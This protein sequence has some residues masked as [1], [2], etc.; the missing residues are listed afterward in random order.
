MSKYLD[1][2]DIRFILKEYPDQIPDKLI[3]DFLYKLH[4]YI[5]INEPLS[6]TGIR[7][8]V[9]KRSIDFHSRRTIQRFIDRIPEN[10]ARRCNWDVDPIEYTEDGEKNYVGKIEGRLEFMIKTKAKGLRTIFVWDFENEHE[11]YHHH[12]DTNNMPK[13]QREVLKEVFV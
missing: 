8:R 10:C 1:M 5:D 9:W 6:K 7:R 11:L 13:L 4:D 3:S 2:D 12:F